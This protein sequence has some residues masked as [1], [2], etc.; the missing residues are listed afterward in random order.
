MK[1]ITLSIISG[2]W[3]ATFT[4]EEEQTIRN[5]MGTNQ[6]ITP[7]HGGVQSDQVVA[8]M[9]RLNPDYEARV[10]EQTKVS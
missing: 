2:N 7:F 10:Q 1:L 5:L 4:G 9:E 3:W 8:H 6:V